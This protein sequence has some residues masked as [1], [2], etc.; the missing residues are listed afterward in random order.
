MKVFLR[1]TSLL[2]PTTQSL[3]AIGE[4]Y[5]DLGLNKIDLPKSSKDNM[6]L[7][8]QEDFNLFKEYAIQDSIITLWHALQVEYSNYEF[9]NSFSIPITFSCN[10]L[11]M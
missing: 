2:S 6:R 7:F 5:S 1:D 8:M 9:S 3:G 10:K 11:L 4:L